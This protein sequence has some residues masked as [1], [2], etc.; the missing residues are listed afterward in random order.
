MEEDLSTAK[1]NAIDKHLKPLIGNFKI[2]KLDRVIYQR[3]FIDKMEGKYKPSSIRIWHSIF[4]IAINAAVE[5]E[6]L[7]RNKFSKVTLPIDDEIKDNY[8]DE[9]DLSIF[10]NYAKENEH[11]TAYTV[12]LTLAYTGMR[13]GELLGLLWEDIDFTKNTITIKRTRD[14]NGIRTPKTKNSYRTI[15]VDQ[16]VM[17]QIQT[18]Q[19][20]CKELLFTFG[21]K[22]SD[23][24]IVFISKILPTQF[25]LTHLSML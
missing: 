11:I 22:I 19:K 25:Q 9:N 2:Q 24:T 6:I 3:E 1:K 5:E 8:L 4:K 21:K 13:R 7:I 15:R 23:D 12:L 14:Y 18:Y 20:W 10:I 16:F 17:D